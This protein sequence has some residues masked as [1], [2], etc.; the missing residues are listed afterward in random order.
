ME[1]DIKKIGV[2]VLIAATFV[3]MVFFKDKWLSVFPLEWLQNESF[4]KGVKVIVDMLVGVATVFVIIQHVKKYIKRKDG[5]NDKEKK[6]AVE[7]YKQ[8]LAERYQYL[9]FKGMGISDRVPLKLRLTDMY[10]PLNARREIPEGE[11]WERHLKVAGRKREDGD[12]DSPM[13]RLGEPR[14]IQ[15]ILEKHDGLIVLGDPGAGKTT[16]LKHLA[17]KLAGNRGADIGLKGFLPILFPLSAYGDHTDVLLSDFILDYHSKRFDADL[18]VRG[19][20]KGALENGKALVLLD[21]LDEVRDLDR[22]GNTVKRVKDFFISQKESGNKFVITSRIVGYREVR[23]V[24]D[25]LGECAIVDFEEGEIQEFVQKWTRAV[26]KH[27]QGETGTAKKEAEKER[28]ELLRAVHRNAGVR[29]LASNPLLLTILALMKRQGIELPERRVELYEKYVD[30]LVKHWNLARSLESCK[31]RAVDLHETVEVLSRTA[32]WMHEENPQKGLV[33]EEALRQRLREAYEDRRAE[34]PKCAAGEFLEDVRRKAG[35]LLERGH[36]EYGFLHL[37]FQEY[38]AGVAVAGKG[39][40]S[41][42]PVADFIEKRLGDDNWREV[43]QLSIGYI[44]IVQRRPEAAGDIL[45]ELIERDPGKPG[46]AL[47][48]AGEAVVDAGP[49]GVPPACYEEVKEKLLS[50]MFNH[51]KFEAPMRA[52]AGMVLGKLGDPRPGVGLDKGGLPDIEWLRVEKGPFMMGSDP[53]KDEFAGD[54]ETPQFTCRLIEESFFIAKYPVTVRQYSAFIKAGGYQSEKY[55][56]KAGWEWRVSQ[57]IDGPER[58]REVFETPNHPQVGVSWYEC[59]AF[60]I[61]F[62]EEMGRSIALPSEA[63]WERAARHTDGRIYLWGN[64]FSEEKCNAYDRGIG[65][66]SAVGMFPNG[67]AKCGASDMAGNV[68]EWCATK[69]LD[70]Y[71]KYEDQADDDHEGVSVRVLRGG[72]CFNY[73]KN[74]RSALRHRLVPGNR[75]FSMGFRLMRSLP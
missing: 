73:A 33:K 63:Q 71:E 18:D 8:N 35:L 61:W 32:L 41:V 10:V 9:D 6:R 66:A 3:F 4:R 70:S 56:T 59:H 51:E 67:D 7:E 39:Q 25:R 64:D 46:T 74:C 49:S 27:V 19:V 15:D 40:K 72:S 62:S 57:K 45:L 20:L 54:T 75:D 43:I 34:D 21:G 26:E 29:D 12:M 42:D 24:V 38:L 13:G 65:H 11:T 60:C 55:W 53:D 22:R 30:T 14:P 47:I 31:T 58:N 50:M 48:A 5:A 23:P 37:T 68:W 44:G 36:K 69:G 2:W 52:R 28:E 17:L 1:R 16:F